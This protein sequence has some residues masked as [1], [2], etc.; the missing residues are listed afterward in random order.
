MKKKMKKK[1]NE[2]NYTICTKKLST[3]CYNAM[4]VFHIFFIFIIYVWASHDSG[5]WS[6]KKKWKNKL[7]ERKKWGKIETSSTFHVREFST[8]Q[9][10]RVRGKRKENELNHLS[11]YLILKD[12]A[13]THTQ[14]IYFTYVTRVKRIIIRILK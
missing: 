9:R 10:I 14:S 1:K 7:N 13:H 5:P 4:N 2:I 6:F 3:F 11:V 12:I 8:K